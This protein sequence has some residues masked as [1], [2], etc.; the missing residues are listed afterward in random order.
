MTVRMLGFR[1]YLSIFQLPFTLAGLL[2]ACKII[3]M[4]ESAII[5]LIGSLSHSK[6]T[7]KESFAGG[8]I[9]TELKTYI[10]NA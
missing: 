1:G 7:L 4:I 2:S 10:N 6:V 9:N 8:K 3:A 5:S